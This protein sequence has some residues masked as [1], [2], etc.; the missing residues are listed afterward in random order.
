MAGEGNHDCVL[1]ARTIYHS[2]KPGQHRTSASVLVNERC[3]LL[4]LVEAGLTN[5]MSKAPGIGR[6]ERQIAGGAAVGAAGVGKQRI[7][8][9]ADKQAQELTPPTPC[10]RWAGIHRHW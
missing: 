9:D 6:G 8:I 3:G 2:A 4:A 7:A 5:C 1:S 10:A